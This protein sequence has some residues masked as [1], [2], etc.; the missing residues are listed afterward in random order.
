MEEYPERK[1]PGCRFP[2]RF[3]GTGTSGMAGTTEKRIGPD[4]GGCCRLGREKQ[5]ENGTFVYCG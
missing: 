3:S 2:G 5:A 4:N 1:I